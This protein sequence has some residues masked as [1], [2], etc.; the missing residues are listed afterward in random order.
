MVIPPHL[1]F[2]YCFFRDQKLKSQ[3]GNLIFPTV[4]S[5]VFL[6]FHLK[7][8]EWFWRVN[9][10]IVRKISCSHSFFWCAVGHLIYFLVTLSS[11]PRDQHMEGHGYVLSIVLRLIKWTTCV[12]CL[13]LSFQIFPPGLVDLKTTQILVFLSTDAFHFRN[14]GVMLA[15][16]IFTNSV[17]ELIPHP[18]PISRSSGFIFFLKNL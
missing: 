3:L 11:F 4:I 13:L 16:K 18:A 12:L 1:L 2:L 7:I 9:I 8:T 17:G 5:R 10:D 15:R 14:T 6:V